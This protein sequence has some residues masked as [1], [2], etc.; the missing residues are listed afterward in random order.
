MQPNTW[1]LCPFKILL[2]IACTSMFSSLCSHTFVEVH[3]HT[4]HFFLL[5]IG[6]KSFPESQQSL[7]RWGLVVSA[8]RLEF[9]I[10]LSC[11]F[12]CQACLTR[13]SCCSPGG[14]GSSSW[15]PV[16]QWVVW[17]VYV[18]EREKNYES[19]S[20]CNWRKCHVYLT[21]QACSV[22]LL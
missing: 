9:F 16:L 10:N 13:F 4:V 3:F 6:N 20:F 19:H 22:T 2:G 18:C 11:F 15:A 8:C 12:L 21:E 17:D 1:Y 7:Y 5:S 14:T